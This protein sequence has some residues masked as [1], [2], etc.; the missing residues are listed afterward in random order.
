MW[1]L[2]TASDELGNSMNYMG[3]AL[4]VWNELSE[5]FSA[6]SGHK[7][8]ETQCDLFKLEQGNDSVEFYFHK[9]KGYWDEIRALEPTVKCTCGAIK[10]WE[11]QLEKT[12]LIQF[13]MGL[14]SSYTAARGQLLMMSP[15]P[16]VNQAFMLLKQEEK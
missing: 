3:S 15:W 9:L 1:I 2:N 11:L 16:T 14:H 12:K 4:T 10:Y 7:Y 6:V 8:Y 5:R 13:L